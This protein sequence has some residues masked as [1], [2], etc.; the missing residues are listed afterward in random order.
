M[1]PDVITYVAGY[2]FKN[3]SYIASDQYKRYRAALDEIHRL[4]VKMQRER[5]AA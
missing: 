1:K 3:G 2:E 4:A 5:D